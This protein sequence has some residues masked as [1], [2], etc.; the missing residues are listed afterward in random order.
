MKILRFIVFTASIILIFLN[1]GP[2]F[3]SGEINIGLITGITIGLMLLIYGILFKKINLI[4]KKLWSKTVGKICVI[5][6][7]AILSFLIIAGG[8]TLINVIRYSHESD[9][10]TEYIIVLGCKV[11]GTEPGRYL[12]A[13][14]NSAFRYLTDNPGS[15]A[16][17]SGGRGDGEDI[18]EGQCMFNELTAR[19]ISSKRLII[20]DK[21]TS[22]YETFNNTLSLL[23]E[24][25]IEIKEI[26]VITNDFH[27]YRAVK[28]AERNGLKAYPY[29]AETPLIGLLP[30]AIREVYAV[31]YQIYLGR[32]KLKN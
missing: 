22:T 21:S 10:K 11:N 15:K 9:K 14:I 6:F 12:K 2:F 17:L 8:F 24:R 31:W 23:N 13:R 28:F 7:S 26:T 30:F 20:E 29:P 25:G 18:S 5:V 3:T 32:N 19:G 27:E 4:I 1:I 16:V